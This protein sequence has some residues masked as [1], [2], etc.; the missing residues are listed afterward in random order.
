MLML[1]LRS[2]LPLIPANNYPKYAV[3]FRKFASAELAVNFLNLDFCK[4][5]QKNIGSI[6]NFM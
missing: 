4:S 2:Y 3:I 1:I 5:K 6:L